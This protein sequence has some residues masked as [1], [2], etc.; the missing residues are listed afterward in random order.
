MKRWKDGTLR[1]G[2]R[3]IVPTIM[4]FGEKVVYAYKVSGIIAGYFKPKEH[5]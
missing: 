5:D 4:K 3:I 2:R 1:I